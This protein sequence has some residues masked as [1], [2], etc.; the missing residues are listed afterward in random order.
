MPKRTAEQ[1]IERYRRKLQ[2]LE[3]MQQETHRQ[4]S[5]ESEAEDCSGKYRYNFIK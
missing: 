1:K 4:Q 2:K 3:E 5:A